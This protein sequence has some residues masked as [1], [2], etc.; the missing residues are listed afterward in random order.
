MGYVLDA[1]AF[2]VR[3]SIIEVI[4]C[5]VICGCGVVVFWIANKHKSVSS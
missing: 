4:G 5:L 1:V 2:G 3:I